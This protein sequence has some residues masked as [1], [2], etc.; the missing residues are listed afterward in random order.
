MRSTAPPSK[1]TGQV[2]SLSG[3][4]ARITVQRILWWSSG[5]A[6][7]P[8]GTFWFPPSLG[9]STASKG[10]FL[11]PRVVPE[12]AQLSHP[13]TSTTRGRTSPPRGSGTVSQSRSQGQAPSAPLA[14]PPRG[15]CACGAGAACR[16]PAAEAAAIRAGSALGAEGA[17]WCWGRGGWGGMRSPASGSM[18]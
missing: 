9:R 1:K 6:H 4:A 10:W 11:I 16:P 15:P 2:G 13:Y 3:H 14:G 7:P 18:L 17:G 8:G 5:A 12:Q